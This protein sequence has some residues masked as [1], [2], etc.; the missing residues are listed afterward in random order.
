[1]PAAPVPPDVEEFLRKPNLAVVATLRPDGSPHTAATWYDWEDG[2][3]LLNME[4]TRLRL[5]F[6]RRDPRAAL[7]VL[8][9][10]SWYRHVSLL[11]RVVRIEDDPDLVGIDRLAVRYT[12]KPFRTR[13]RKRVSAWLLPERWHE[14]GD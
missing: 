8:D 4:D 1:M 7:T 10:D 11:G 2:L 6:L 12:G 5:R 3:V 9:A 13:D 14:W